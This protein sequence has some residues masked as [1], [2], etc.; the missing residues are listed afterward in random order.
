[1]KWVP[2][3]AGVLLL[4]ACELDTEGFGGSGGSWQNGGGFGGSGGSGQQAGL[5]LAREVCVRE[6][7]EQGRVVADV[8]RVREVSIGSTAIGADVY[9][10]VRRDPMTVSTTSV[11]CR[12][13][14]S[15][16]TAQISN[17]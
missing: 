8:T 17:T 9:M 16:G 4:A 15:S 10:Q 5:E 14:Y 13:S 3:L 7:R 1:M 6:V 2:A 12:F 11:R